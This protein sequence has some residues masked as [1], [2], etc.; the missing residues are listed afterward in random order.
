MTIAREEPKES[1]NNDIGVLVLTCLSLLPYPSSLWSLYRGTGSNPG[2]PSPAY[3]AQGVLD[4]SFS[5]GVLTSHELCLFSLANMALI[6]LVC[7]MLGLV[8][9]RTIL[10]VLVAIHLTL[11]LNLLILKLLPDNVPALESD[12]KV[13]RILIIFQYIYDFNL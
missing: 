12:Q 4:T 11:I 2:L 5:Q 6:L 7:V 8:R 13:I 9:S 10:R 3:L 1:S